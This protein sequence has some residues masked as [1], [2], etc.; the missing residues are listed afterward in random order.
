MKTEPKLLPCTSWII[1]VAIVSC[2]WSTAAPGQSTTDQPNA[3]NP[4]AAGGDQSTPDEDR[5]QLFKKL[6]SHLTGAK[7]IGQ[8]K[9]SGV[10]ILVEVFLHLN[11]GV[12]SL[13]VL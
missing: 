11:V 1:L 4:K 8:K 12:S 2:C 6:E 10:E 7:L 3:A 13:L 9:C 5:S